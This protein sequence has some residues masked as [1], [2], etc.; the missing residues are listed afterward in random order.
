MNIVVVGG[1]TYS[2]W[3]AWLPRRLSNGDRVWLT[4]YYLRPDGNGQGLLLSWA[5]VKAKSGH[6]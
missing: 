4:Y 5:E 1:Q 6:G 3:F 2:R